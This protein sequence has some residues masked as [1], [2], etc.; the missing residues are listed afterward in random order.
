MSKRKS[1]VENSPSSLQFPV[2]GIGASAGGLEAVKQFLQAVPKK[3][4]M[5][6]VFVQHLSP[7]H[8]SY[9]PE[10]LE[11]FSKIPV[12]QIA[13]IC[14]WKRIIFILCPPTGLSKQEMAS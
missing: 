3:S 7:T 9:L 5:A 1:T 11:K 4:G 8:E 2:V 6:Y 12:R 10:I 13:D 14:R